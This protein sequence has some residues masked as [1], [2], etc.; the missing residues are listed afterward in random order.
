MA[1]LSDVQNALVTLI[2]QALYP[3]GTAQASVVGNPCVVYPGWPNATGLDNDLANGKVHITVFNRP[4]EKN[5]TR[6]PGEWQTVSI[7]DATL[8]LEIAGNTLTINGSIHTPQNVSIQVNGAAYVYPVQGNDTLTSTATALAAMIPNTASSGNVITFAN[9][10]EIIA[11]IGVAGMSLK[12]INR[13]SKRFQICVWAPSPDVRVTVSKAIKNCLAPIEFI[14]LADTSRAY[15]VYQSTHEIDE[16]QKISLYRRDMFFEI[17][18]ADTLVQDDM[19][20]TQGIVNY[21]GFV[22]QIPNQSGM[23][24]KVITS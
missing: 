14:T 4:E 17:E 9:N 18:Y 8:S 6:Y 2:A 7:D 23:P 21:Q 24:V 10:A 3:N 11:R 13:Q 5:T 19:T 12:E 15:V 1:D 22:V 20:I 16:L